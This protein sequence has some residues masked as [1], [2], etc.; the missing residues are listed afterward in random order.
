MA[1]AT[2]SDAKNG[3]EKNGAERKFK[4]LTAIRTLRGE[5]IKAGSIVTE[6]EIQKQGLKV[7]TLIRRGSLVDPNSTAEKRV[8]PQP[9]PQRRP[10][11]VSSLAK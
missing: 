1:E 11:N 7:E 4:T 2:K 8:R 9:G 6:S 10:D 5:P 3:A